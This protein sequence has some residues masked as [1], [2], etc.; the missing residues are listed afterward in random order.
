MFWTFELIVQINVCVIKLQQIYFTV[1]SW[2]CGEL[3]VKTC[4]CDLVSRGRLWW[5]IALTSWDEI[6]GTDTA[7]VKD[8][9]YLFPNSA[10]GLTVTGQEPGSFCNTKNNLNEIFR[11]D[12]TTLDT[13][14][15]KM[16]YRSKGYFPSCCM[17]I[18]QQVIIVRFKD[19]VWSYNWCDLEAYAE[20][21]SG[22]IC[23]TSCFLNG[24]KF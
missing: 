3:L 14:C 5:T 8:V 21:S 4:H 16:S 22:S 24:V 19:P 23:Q 11:M 20:L 6:S 13:A 18:E 7:L 1:T 17:T 12:G 10:T 15:A 9:P 2:H